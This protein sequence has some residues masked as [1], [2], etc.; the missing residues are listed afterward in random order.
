MTKIRSY[1]IDE[2]HDDME[3][4]LLDLDPCSDDAAKLRA[5]IE[6]LKHTDPDMQRYLE[7]RE[8]Y[9]MAARLHTQEA[10]RVIVITLNEAKHRRAR[11]LTSLQNCPQGT[12]REQELRAMIRALDKEIAEI[13]ARSAT[14]AAQRIAGEVQP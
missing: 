10:P 11:L 4:T 1:R 3:E 14:A 12:E 8:I 5:A 7:Q 2:V 9:A 13:N 6:Q